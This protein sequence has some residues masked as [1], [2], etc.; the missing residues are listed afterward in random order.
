MADSDQHG[1][2]LRRLTE[3]S[4]NV[5]AAHDRYEA[6]RTE[7]VDEILAA[8]DAGVPITHIG[9]ACGLA[10]SRVYQIIEGAKT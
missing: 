7:R 2:R 6:L 4:G 5:E 3:L 1:E 10:R 9:K 8:V